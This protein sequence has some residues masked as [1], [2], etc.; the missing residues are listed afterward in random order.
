[1]LS[2]VW[3]G[4][5]GWPWPLGVGLG[6]GCGALH[7]NSSYGGD[8]EDGRATYSEVLGNLLELIT[9]PGDAVVMSTDSPFLILNP[10]RAPV[11]PRA[12]GANNSRGSSF[13]DQATAV[14][15]KRSLRVVVLLF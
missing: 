11:W 15:N 3:G 2:P 10:G 13:T 5:L 12:L 6:P 1:M 14:E 4:T 7:S 9:D 8:M